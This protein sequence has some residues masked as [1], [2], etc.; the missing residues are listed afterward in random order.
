MIDTSQRSNE[1]LT[2]LFNITDILTQCIRYQQMYI[3]M[4]TILAYLRDFL[5]YM[6]QGAIHTMDCVDAAI[7]NI[8]SSDK[9]PVEDLRSMLRQIE[10]ELPSTMH[11]HISLDDMHHFY[12][13]LNTHVS[14]AE[15]QFLLLISV[16][17]QNNAQQLQIY[18]VFN[19]PAP[20][21]NLSPQYKINHM[22]M[23]V[24]YHE[25]KAFATMDQQYMAC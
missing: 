2:R 18:E 22:Y 16:P 7:T 12:W 13:Y 23:A 19:L 21:S 11:L 14:I 4:S 15:G 25:T 8:L 5:T 24:A 20:H 3:Y 6:R 17:I 1:D 9:L 10:S